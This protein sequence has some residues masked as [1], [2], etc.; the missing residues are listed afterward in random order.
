MNAE[1]VDPGRFPVTFETIEQARRRIADRIVLTPFNAA[2]SLSE[3]CGSKLFLKLEGA[4]KTGAF[5]ERGALNRLLM[6]PPDR[7][8]R[9]VVAASAGNHAQ[10]LSLHATRLGV[11]ATIVMPEWTPLVKVARTRRFG[12][13]VVL[14][15]ASYDDA[16]A[17]ALALC[18]SEGR[19]FIHAFNDSGVISGQGT[20][21]LEMLEQN[22]YIQ[23]LVVPIGG[24]GF[25]SGIACAIK[26]TNPR[27]RVVGVETAAVPSMK[28]SVE[29]GELVTT[30]PARTIADGIAVR[31]PGDPTFEL[32]QRYVDD[33]VTVSEEEI[34]GAIILLMEEEK[35]I[36]EGAGAVG[37]AALLQG[38]IPE[39]I[40]KRT[41]VVISGGNIDLNLISHIIERGL[42][43]AGRMV[44]LDVTIP[45]VPGSLARLTQIVGA[46]SANIL[47]IHHDR[48]FSPISFGETDVSLSLETR[49]YEHI[50]RLARRLRDEG[51]V[52]RTDLAA[53]LRA[54]AIE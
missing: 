45:D 8:A 50:D 43:K 13:E 23:C 26:E 5:K 17:Y 25:I 6:T 29:R 44:R 15:G 18:E 48:A 33:I 54:D 34:A 47:E 42:V 32:V 49:G 22:P 7:L 14:H 35:V 4:Q 27:I 20:A 31:T 2:E 52:V 39:A 21:A 46:E 12:A 30:G 40:G 36:A 53:Q 10:A 16:C 9:G 24:G 19:T 1:Q 41:G 28:L 3:L 37:V 51:Y 11:R 38:R